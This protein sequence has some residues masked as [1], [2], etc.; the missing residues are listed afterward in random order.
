MSSEGSGWGARWTQR[1]LPTCGLLP[2]SLRFRVGPIRFKGA[3]PAAPGAELSSRVY[4]RSGCSVG[5]GGRTGFAKGW[6]LVGSCSPCPGGLGGIPGLGF[7]APVEVL[8]GG[9]DG[10]GGS[11]LHPPTCAGLGFP[12][13]TAVVHGPVPAAEACRFHKMELCDAIHGWA[14]PVGI[15]GSQLPRVAA[16]PG[17]RPQPSLEPCATPCGG[18]GCGMP[19]HAPCW[20]VTRL[21]ALLVEQAAGQELSPRGP[22]V[23]HQVT[24]P[25]CHLCTSPATAWR[26]SWRDP[27]GCAPGAGVTLQRR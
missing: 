10:A 2:A 6:L 11:P 21:T 23:P 5:R 26:R 20:V 25:G 27:T 3:F 22:Q 1:S 8:A 7:R 14:R 19:R 17:G 4:S 9:G 12:H 24:P 13:P 15:G 16:G 18:A